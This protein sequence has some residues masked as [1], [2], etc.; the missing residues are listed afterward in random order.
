M[1]NHFNAKNAVDC[2]VEWIRTWVNSKSPTAKVYIGISGGKD[3]TVAAALCV[4]A[5]GANR[6]VGVLMPNGEQPDIED[7]YKVCNF[8]NINR[9][10]FDI[11]RIVEAF[12]DEAEICDVEH[13]SGT[14][15]SRINLP[16]RV[17][18]SALYFLAQCAGDSFVVNTCNACEN[19]VGYSTRWGD[20]TGD[21]SPLGGYTVSE[22]I[23]LGDALGLPYELVHKTPSDGLC[24]KTDEENLGFTYD[25]IEKVMQRK[26]DEVPEDTWFAIEKKHKQNLFKTE[27]P[28]FFSYY[29]FC[30]NLELGWF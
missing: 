9:H 27:M 24:G 2:T 18:M 1:R 28:E 19:Y 16:P 15:V 23:A 3:S 29:N 21:F 7:S 12:Y 8:L 20:D 10:Y 17:R 26:R 14:D 6:V 5:L 30:A 4:K 25:E 11:S 22:V 13:C